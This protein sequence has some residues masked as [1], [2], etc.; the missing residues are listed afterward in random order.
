MTARLL[1]LSL[2]LW[3]SSLVTAAE[4][5]PAEIM[6]RAAELTPVDDQI[7]TLTFKFK[8]V[9]KEEKML[10]Y[11][12]FWQQMDKESGYADRTIFFSQYPP[13]QKGVAFM[14]WMRAE[15]DLREDDE[16][17]YLPEL[18]IVRR[19]SKRDHDHKHHD[20]VFGHSVLQQQQ[21]DPRPPNLDQHQ[22]KELVILDNRT[23]YVITSQPIKP[24]PDYP[25]SK[26]E[27]WI[28][29][30]TFTPSRKLFFDTAGTLVVDMSLEWRNIKERWVWQKVT[31]INPQTEATT[32]L[33]ISDIEVNIGLTESDFSKRALKLGGK[34]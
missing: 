23:Y 30:V 1:L 9:K 28:D 33:E 2:V 17:L 29:Q 5:S 24:D 8:E 13:D 19:V 31:A 11:R 27:T 25:F 14:S 26:V 21:L 12:M 15:G 10:V 22:L 7:S 18:Q 6:V 16:W 20:D 3:Q 32:R 34:R 4:L